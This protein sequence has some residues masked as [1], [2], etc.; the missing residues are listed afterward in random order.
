MQ[1]NQI[2]LSHASIALS[3]LILAM[4]LLSILSLRKKAPEKAFQECITANHFSF[5]TSNT[6]RGAAVIVLIIGHLSVKDIKAFT[7]YEYAGQW[8]VTIFLFVSG[9]ALGKTYGLYKVGKSFL[10]KRIERLIFPVWLT[11]I[12]FYSLDFILL[13]KIHSPAKIIFSFF[14]M[15]TFGPPNGPAWFISYILFFYTLFFV[16]SFLYTNEFSKLLIILLA[17]YFV[18]YSIKFFHLNKLAL[19]PQYTIIF[20]ISVLIGISLE[21][22]WNVLKAFYN[23]SKIIYF[24]LIVCLFTL[25]YKYPLISLIVGEKIFPSHIRTLIISLRPMYLIICV[26]MVSYFLDSLKR[27]SKFLLFLGDYSFEIY[28]LHMPFLVYYDFFLFRKPF[29]LFFFA[30][31][32]FILLLSYLLK[33]VSSSLN[34]HIFRPVIYRRP[35]KSYQS[36]EVKTQRLPGWF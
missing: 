30:Y 28:L 21:K 24:L 27:E 3:L 12:L 17:S 29:I 9:I 22:I 35:K 8:A 19:W 6:L 20:P 23:Y 34:R 26:A 1:K 15:I 7:P 13:N 10:I 33:T 5:S 4:F 2:T 16:V 36:A 11:L 14:G 32:I 18:T 31:F 25:Y